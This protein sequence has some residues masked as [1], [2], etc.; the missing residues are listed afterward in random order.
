MPDTLNQWAAHWRIPEAALVDLRQRLCPAPLTVP[1]RSGS[2]AAVQQ[3]V[4]LAAAR[5]GVLLWRNNVGALLDQRGIPVRY[6][7]ANDTK[8]TNARTKSADLIGVRPV[9]ITPAHVGTT[10]G[11][12]VSVEVKRPG[13]RWSGDAHELAQLNWASLIWSAGGHAVFAD[14]PLTLAYQGG[15]IGH[16]VSRREP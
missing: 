13:W 1:V 4:R 11:Q 2:E 12:F 10:L 16:L 8:A 15:L 9:E 6:G 7:L 14:G 5:D 3:G